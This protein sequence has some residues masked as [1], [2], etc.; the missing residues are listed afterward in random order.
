[1]DI[2]TQLM[3]CDTIPH[4]RSPAG[5]RGNYGR[6]HARFPLQ[7]RMPNRNL[8]YVTP[9]SFPKIKVGLGIFRTNADCH[10]N[11]VYKAFIVWSS[12]NTFLVL[13]NRMRLRSG[14]FRR[15]LR[16]NVFLNRK[17]PLRSRNFFCKYWTKCAD[18]D[19]TLP[20]HFDISNVHP[21]LHGY[22]KCQCSAFGF[23]ASLSRSNWYWP[24][25]SFPQKRTPQRTPKEF[26]EMPSKV[27]SCENLLSFEKYQTLPWR[28]SDSSSPSSFIHTW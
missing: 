2:P 3:G 15:I 12:L 11:P 25:D 16:P 6:G 20:L 22:V 21:I 10:W 28:S 27:D 7:N 8:S 1:M 5:A 14:D 18:L 24:I 19:F 23:A 4:L 13:A 9:I 26:D 17:S